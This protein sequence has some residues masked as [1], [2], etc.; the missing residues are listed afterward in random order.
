MS[1]RSDKYLRSLR[2]VYHCSVSETQSFIVRDIWQRQE[3]VWTMWPFV[4]SFLYTYHGV[5]GGRRIIAPFILKFGHR[6]KWVIS[7]TPRLLYPG[8][9]LPMFVDWKTW[10]ALVLSRSLGKETFLHLPGID[11]VFLRCSAYKMVTTLT[12]PFLWACEIWK[13]KRCVFTT[14]GKKITSISNTSGRGSVR[15]LAC[16]HLFLAVM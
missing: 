16:I 11:P 7:F 14:I 5:Y 2:C 9:E 6:R 15:F 10:W 3:R 13:Q 1:H 8:E 12:A 4:Q